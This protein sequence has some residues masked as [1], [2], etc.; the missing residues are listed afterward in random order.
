MSTLIVIL[1]RLFLFFS[2]YSSVSGSSDFYLTE[3]F[4]GGFSSPHQLWLDS[5]NNYLYVARDALYMSRI[6]VSSRAVTV[7]AGNGV[8]ND[9]IAGPVTSSPMASCYGVCGDT[10][11]SLYVTCITYD[12]IVKID[13]PTGERE[14][15][16]KRD[17]ERVYK[18]TTFISLKR[19]LFRFSFKI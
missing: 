15:E 10:A 6:A 14:K 17:R 3:L 16:R 18:R 7:F 19:K 8:I 1:A 2:L 9:H 12:R 13:I 4:A 5:L 11:G